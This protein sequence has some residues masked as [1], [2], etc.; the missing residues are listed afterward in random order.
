MIWSILFYYFPF[1]RSTQYFVIN[2]RVFHSFFPVI[3]IIVTIRL[4]TSEFPLEFCS[5]FWVFHTL[6]ERIDCWSTKTSKDP[7]HGGGFS[8]PC[9]R[10]PSLGVLIKDYSFKKSSPIGLL[11]WIFLVVFCF[12]PHTTFLLQGFSSYYYRSEA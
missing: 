3:I 9:C 2:K 7:S 6:R 10:S 8:Y 4:L 11:H 12:G 1:S 5:L